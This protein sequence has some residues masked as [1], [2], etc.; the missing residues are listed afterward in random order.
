MSKAE[1]KQ[2]DVVDEWVASH[3]VLSALIAVAVI[4]VTVGIGSLLPDKGPDII[5]DRLSRQGFDVSHITFE[6][7][8]QDS[9]WS[10][11]RI[12]RAS[13]AIEYV[14]GVLV[15]EWKVTDTSSPSRFFSSW[16]VTPY[17]ALPSPV[18]VTLRL[19]ISQEDYDLLA[20][21][22]EGQT[23]EEYLKQ[24]VIDKIKGADTDAS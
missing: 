18:E 20:G 5:R 6:K 4:A 1:G 21:Q 7:V 3:K 15:H 24:Y 12:Y 8:E 2:R 17:P 19:S 14:P 10:A 11:G 22:A 9:F 23:V 13:K 16:S